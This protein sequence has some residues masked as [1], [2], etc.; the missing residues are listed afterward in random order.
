KG[1]NDVLLQPVLVRVRHKGPPEKAVLRVQGTRRINLNLREGGESV[2]ALVPAA[3]RPETRHL[4][5]EIEGQVI[6]GRNIRLDPVHKLTIYVLPHSHT[7]IG[8]T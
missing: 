7:D 8:Y 1:V 3:S 2:E 5:L 4:E 6:G